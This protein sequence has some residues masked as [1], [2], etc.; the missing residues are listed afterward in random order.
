[1][2]LIVG[3]GNPEPIYDLTRHNIGFL[4]LDHAAQQLK[5]PWRH[6]PKFKAIIAEAVIGGE[7]TILLKP[8]TYYNLSGEA[9]RAA[10]NFYKITAQDVLVL[11]D[12]L[13][14]PFG[15]LRTRLGGSDAGNNGIKS[16]IAHLGTDF[17]RIRA[18]IANDHAA[19][20]DAADFVLSRF[21]PHEQKQLEKLAQQSLS[22][23]EDFVHHER[24]FAPTSIKLQE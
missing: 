23:I 6:Q 24:E 21:T 15:T 17:A 4:L 12:E 7:K 20:Q 18:G 14:L 1:M 11:H 19:T 5:A 8:T 2:K 3:L 10:L 16:I 22:F 13:A 9:V